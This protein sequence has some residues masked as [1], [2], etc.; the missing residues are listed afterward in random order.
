MEQI[1]REDAAA[2]PNEYIAGGGPSK[3]LRYYWCGRCSTFHWEDERADYDNHILHQ[4]RDGIQYGHRPALG[5][6]P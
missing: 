2:L 4:T 1:A 6:L 5:L 3:L